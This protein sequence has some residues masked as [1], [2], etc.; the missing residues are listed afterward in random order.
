[1][2]PERQLT[3]SHTY[4]ARRP[5]V[6]TPHPGVHV[7]YL[8]FHGLWLAEAG[9]PIGSKVCVEVAVGRLVVTP[10]TSPALEA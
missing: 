10:S 3:V 9:F 1:M 8:R 6:Y 4:R 7:P 2:I 5:R